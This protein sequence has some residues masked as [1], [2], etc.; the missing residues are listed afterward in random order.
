MFSFTRPSQV[1]TAVN[2]CATHFY[3]S[4]L[5]DL[6]SDAAWQVYKT[7][8]TC[9]KLTWDIPRWSHNYFVD[10]L[11]SGDIPSTR[12]KVLCQYVNFFNKLRMSPSRE[13]RVLASIVG[14]DQESVTG[15][16]LSHL[17]EVFSLDPWTQHVTQFHKMYQ[18]YSVPEQERWRL[19]LLVKL[20]E[21]R[22]VMAACEEEVE[23]ITGLIDSLCSS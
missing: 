6:S 13:V 12:Q 16:N 4:M 23:D 3:G 7:W 11:L 19:P 5:W 20:L 10:S 17:S 22:R 21:Q 18:G 9:V 14:R 2:V 1:L 15:R 8:N